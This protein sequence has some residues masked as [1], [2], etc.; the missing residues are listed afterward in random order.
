MDFFIEV[1]KRMFLFNSLRYFVVSGIAFLIFYVLFKKKWQFKK[2]QK[3]F[4]Q[5]KDYYREIGYSLLTILIFIAIGLAIFAS[6]IREY[7]QLYS[8]IAEYG[9]GYWFLS[10]TIMIFLHD[11]YFYWAHRIMHHPKLF[12]TFHLVHHKSVN[13]SPWASYAFHPFEGIVEAGIIIPIAFFIPFHLTAL[14]AFLF[15][16]MSYNVYGHL[17]YELFPKNFHKNSI[18]KWVNTSVNHN[19]HHKYFKGNYGLY[20]L[21]W[22]RWMGTIREDYD[23]AYEAVSTK[24]SNKLYIE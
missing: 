13:P 16:M 11:T 2:I 10:V 12:K 4:P 8:E 1:S 19:Q 24:R 15:I 23:E 5:N 22:D 17:G 7:T 3:K 21:F 18:G 14:A 6:P 20:F 9:W